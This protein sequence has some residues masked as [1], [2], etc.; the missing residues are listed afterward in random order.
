MLCSFGLGALFGLTLIQ[1]EAIDSIGAGIEER[2][3]LPAGYKA[4]PYYPTPNGGWIA[5]WN[6]SYA[7]AAAVVQNM[8]LAEKVNL[9][10]GVGYFMVRQWFSSPI[11]GTPLFKVSYIRQGLCVGNTGSALRFG[12]PSLCLQDSVRP[13]LLEMFDML[14]P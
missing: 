14:I 12:I 10:S 5:S 2:D 7:K 3:S 13:R 9:T 8:T 11:K 6:E 1:A 4:S